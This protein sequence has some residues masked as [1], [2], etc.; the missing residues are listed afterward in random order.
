MYLEVRL[1]IT[2]TQAMI[3]RINVL[4]QEKSACLIVNF[5][6]NHKGNRN[7]NTRESALKNLIVSIPKL[8]RNIEDKAILEKRIL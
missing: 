8:Q 4:R 2:N 3:P 5:C 6:E 7:A 1:K